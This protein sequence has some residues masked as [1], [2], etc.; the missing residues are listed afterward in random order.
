MKQRLYIIVCVYAPSYTES[1]A[2]A[3]LLS[4]ASKA[5]A[6]GFPLGHERKLHSI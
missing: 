6:L 3:V 2:A 1:V 4:V 5:M